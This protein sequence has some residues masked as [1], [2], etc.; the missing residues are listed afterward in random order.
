MMEKHAMAVVDSE[1]RV[2]GLEGL[3]VIGALVR[4]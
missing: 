2:R 1:R 4:A 3:R